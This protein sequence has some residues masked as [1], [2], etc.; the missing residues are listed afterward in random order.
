MAGTKRAIHNSRHVFVTRV[1]SGMRG[2]AT[3]AFVANG[4]PF[5][6]FNLPTTTLTV[7]RR[8]HPRG[9]IMIKNLVTST[10][11]ASFLANV[12]RP[13]RFSFLFMTP[14]LFTIRTIFTNL[15]FVAVRLLSMGVNVAF[16]NNLVSCVL[17]NLV[18]P[19]AGT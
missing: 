2:L 8:T 17:F 12:A 14:V 13:L 1:D 7:C 4:F 10:T 15:S 3:N 16:S 6:V 19:R 9:G 11:L 5:V 18:G